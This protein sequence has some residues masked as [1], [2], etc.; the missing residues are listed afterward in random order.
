MRAQLLARFNRIMHPL[1]GAFT[2]AMSQQTIDILSQDKAHCMQVRPKMQCLPNLNITELM[3]IW[4]LGFL[5]V[6]N[7]ETF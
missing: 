1:L 2:L 7:F 5:N 6:L 3:P 4:C